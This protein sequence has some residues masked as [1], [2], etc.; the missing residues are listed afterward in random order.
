LKQKQCRILSKK[1]RILDLF[2]RTTTYED[3]HSAIKEESLNTPEIARQNIFLFGPVEGLPL[4]S[5]P[6]AG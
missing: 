4:L 1:A 2:D 6:L 5:Q 3:T